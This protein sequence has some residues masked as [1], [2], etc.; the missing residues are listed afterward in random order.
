MWS[1]RARG[2][3]GSTGTYA[4]PAFHTA[5]TAT[6]RSTD[7]GSEMAT[8]VSGPTPSPA[9]WPASRLARRPSSP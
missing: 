7:L 2:Y 9:R 1:I 4:P 5:S 8:R 3:S 6:T